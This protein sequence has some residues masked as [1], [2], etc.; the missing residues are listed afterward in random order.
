MESQVPPNAQCGL[1][2][3]TN[4]PFVES[5]PTSPC[6][7]LR[8]PL[9][10]WRHWSYQRPCCHCLMWIA[11]K[12]KCT[13]LVRACSPGAAMC[14]AN[15]RHSARVCPAAE[16][17]VLPT[18]TPDLHQLQHGQNLFVPPPNWLQARLPDGTIVGKSVYH[19]LPDMPDK[20]KE[21][22]SLSL[23]SHIAEDEQVDVIA[24]ADRLKD[25]FQL[26][27]TASQISLSVHRLGSTLIL[28]KGPDFATAMDVHAAAASL[29]GTE[30]QATRDR[31]LYSKFLYRSALPPPVIPRTPPEVPVSEAKLLTDTYLESKQH[32]RERVLARSTQAQAAATG[33]V[34]VPNLFFDEAGIAH[35]HTQPGPAAALTSAHVTTARAASTPDRS[36][37]A[38]AHPSPPPTAAVP[39]PQQ[40][41][42][43]PHEAVPPLRAFAE[44]DTLKPPPFRRVCNWKF[45]GYNM[46]LGSDLLAFKSADGRPVSLKLQDIERKL[47]QGE[48]LDMYL[49]N[50]VSCSVTSR[51]AEFVRGLCRGLRRYFSRS[52][53]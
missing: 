6:A 11:T 18:S 43:L 16:A 37:A 46:L 44:Q 47:T 53:F 9:C 12:T 33:A 10:R 23:A 2:T 17:I 49:D 8:L 28:D 20:D 48:C 34:T 22:W 4:P 35:T 19:G 42:G 32:R 14:A 39:A 45:N 29:M 40:H 24:P 51:A 52:L 27:Y 21:M 25:L 3:E 7:A 15:S 30:A 31:E 38:R 1:Y 36:S 26:P 5:S 50:T 41:P 13:A